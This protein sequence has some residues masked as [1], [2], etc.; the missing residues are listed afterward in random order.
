MEMS[1]ANVLFIVCDTLRADHVGCYGY[2]RNTSPNIDRIAAEGVLFEDFYNAGCPTGPAYTCMY[3][4]LYPI[5]HGFYAFVPPNAPAMSDEIFTLPEI[6]QARGYTTAALD[7]LMN[8][9]AHPK[10]FVRGYE[11]YIN[12][13]RDPFMSPP[14]IIAEQINRRL[15][16]WI[17]GH[18]KERFF[19]FVHYWDPHG[20]Y[21]QPKEYREVFHHEKGS[22]SD[23]EV[24]EAPAGYKYVPGWGKADQIFEGDEIRSIDLYDGEIAY[25][26]RAIGEVFQALKD[27]GVFEETLILVTS[28]H[29]EQL[30]QHN[31]YG[32]NALHDAVTHI[33]LIMRYPKRLPRGRRV[34][35][36]AQHID[37]L[38]TILELTGAP[39]TVPGI[40]GQSL[41]PLLEGRELRDRVFMEQVGLQRAIRTKDWK[42]IHFMRGRGR[43]EAMYE[44][45]HVARDPM[46][47][48]NL[49]GEE[50]KEGRLLK[51]TLEEWVKTSLKE[52][53]EDPM[54]ASRERRPGGGQLEYRQRALELVEALGLESPYLQR[55]REAPR[56]ARPRKWGSL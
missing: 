24:R 34:R 55:A 50:E 25:M 40:D 46:E 15:T 36:F 37:L 41:V 52:G 16:P 4:G 53:E 48:I 26:D 19:L 1:E 54:L 22:L 10:H 31:A 9:P 42:L 14:Q 43:E 30:G 12:A 49:E 23:L 51:E 3:T 11:F 39:S 18:S 29:G 17:R 20:P 44:L 5:H 27:E 56:R 45:Y 28:D 21:N 47:A 33:P 2:F 7:N 35:G 8:F 38:P 32:H 6:M 13:S